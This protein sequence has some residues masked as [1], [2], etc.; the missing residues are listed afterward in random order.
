MH[1][2]RLLESDCTIAATAQ[3]WAD[4][5]V[6]EQSSG[7]LGKQGS[8]HCV[9]NLAWGHP[10]RTELDSTQAWYDEIADTHS[11]SSLVTGIYSD[12]D[13][14]VVGHCTQEVWKSPDRTR[15]RHR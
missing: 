2:V 6:Y 3:P 11:G 13:S 5:D 1:D 8:E 9:E 4:N 10:T 7:D 12:S 15:M 14:K